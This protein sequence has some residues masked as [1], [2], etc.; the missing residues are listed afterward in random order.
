MS[1]GIP[2]HVGLYYSY[3]PSR[4]GG[5]KGPC[6]RILELTQR[7]DE[8]HAVCTGIHYCFASRAVSWLTE[9]TQN[10]VLARVIEAP[11][12]P[13]TPRTAPGLA[14]SLRGQ[15]GVH[16]EPGG[17]GTPARSELFW[18]RVSRGGARGG[19]CTTRCRG[20]RTGGSLARGERRRLARCALCPAVRR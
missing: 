6:M 7:G 10:P 19:G 12:A 18:V 13:P 5:P 3:R 9:M 20:G 8:L 17:A 2:I 14:G 11:A 1:Q 16:D 4:G 15:G